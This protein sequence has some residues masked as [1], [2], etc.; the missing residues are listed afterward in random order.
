LVGSL[1]GV[2]AELALL[3]ADVNE[4]DGAGP[5][6]YMDAQARVR[7]FGH[8][9]PRGTALHHAA[10]LDHVECAV[11]LLQAHNI[12]VNAA[13]RSGDTPLHCAAQGGNVRMV[14]ALLRAG[15]DPGLKNHLGFTPGLITQGVPGVN[16]G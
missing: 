4:V 2:K 7:R 9:Q 1:A 6:A 13:T 12:D 5:S 10:C 8:L 16:F 14:E 3:G 11:A 15:A